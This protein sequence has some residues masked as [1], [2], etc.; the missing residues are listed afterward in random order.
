M[1]TII[2]LLNVFFVVLFVEDFDV[3]YLDVEVV[4]FDLIVILRVADVS[5]CV[6]GK[7]LDREFVID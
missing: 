5:Q 3:D 4:V 7:R 2:P 1:N 6:L